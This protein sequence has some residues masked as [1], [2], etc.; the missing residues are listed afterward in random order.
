VG[1]PIGSLLASSAGRAGTTPCRKGLCVLAFRFNA[2]PSC[3]SIRCK[4]AVFNSL[5]N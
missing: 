4:D 3:S 5:S 1:S 2:K